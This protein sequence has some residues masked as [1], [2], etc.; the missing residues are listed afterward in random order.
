MFFVILDM[1]TILFLAFVFWLISRQ[2][3]QQFVHILFYL[4]YFKYAMMSH[5]ALLSF[6]YLYVH[7]CILSVNPSGQVWIIEVAWIWARPISIVWSSEKQNNGCIQNHKG[8]LCRTRAKQ[9]KTKKKQT[10]RRAI[11]MISEYKNS[12]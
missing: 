5:P 11:Y 9:T 6:K 1:S 4:F 8:N 2:V 12:L 3:S 7:L 10:N